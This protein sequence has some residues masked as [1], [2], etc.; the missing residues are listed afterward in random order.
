MKNLNPLLFASMML[1]LGMG[2]VMAQKKSTVFISAINTA[3]YSIE[4]IK[5]DYQ[6]ELKEMDRKEVYFLVALKQEV[7]AWLN[8]GYKIDDVT[9]SIVG[10]TLERF[11]FVLSKEE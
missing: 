3:R 5:P 6:V 10:T 1:F 7:D 2:S 8:Q 9:T 11:V 4:I